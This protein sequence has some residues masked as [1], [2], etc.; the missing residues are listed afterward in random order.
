MFSDKVYLLLPTWFDMSCLYT[1]EIVE[2]K[3]RQIMN[4]VE[5]ICCRF[6]SMVNQYKNVLKWAKFSCRIS[7]DVITS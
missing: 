3:S 1:D 7:Y 4:C 6:R 5:C 2:K